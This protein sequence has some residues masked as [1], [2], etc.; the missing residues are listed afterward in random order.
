M[1][2]K[3]FITIILF[4][5]I[6]PAV[7][8]S[9]TADH[10]VISEFQISDNEFIKLYNPTA[11]EV[12]LDGWYFS[13]FSSA[14]DWNNPVRNKQFPAGA[15]IKS[16]DYYTIGLKGVA[17]PTANWQP[18]KSAQLNNSNGSIAIYPWDPSEKTSV[19]AEEGKIDAVAW[20]NISFVVEGDPLK[21]GPSANESTKRISD[22]WDTD[23]NLDDFIVNSETGEDETEENIIIEEPINIGDV[24]LSEIMPNPSSPAMDSKDEWIELR[25]D[26]GRRVDLGG[27]VLRD[28]V[29]SVHEYIIPEGTYIEA[30]RFAIFYSSATRISL[31]N[32]GD[33]VEF[34][35][36]DGSVID[37]TG[38]EYGKAE[39]GYSYAFDGAGWRWT[40]SPT[41]LG[42]NIISGEDKDEDKEASNTS[43]KSTKSKKSKKST[44]GTNKDNE[45]VKG[46]SANG[47]AIREEDFI[48]KSNKSFLNDRSFGISLIIL[49]G[50]LGFNYIIFREKIYEKI[51]QKS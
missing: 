6:S 20:G 46:S 22:G 17:I 29:G 16:N 31:N 38:D 15:T 39:A 36:R 1:K 24:S 5:F 40:K 42:D 50:L 32:S 43:K 10:I 14:R 51:E 33:F 23:N 12:H 35:D 45:G 25:N 19:Q 13:Y 8:F 11:N 41:P 9:K 30:G 28:G 21:S 4:I 34:L 7:S 27:A 2:T 26:S 48:E 37:S 18:Y 3:I 44:K 49:G 47:A